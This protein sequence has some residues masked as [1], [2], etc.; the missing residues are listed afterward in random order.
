MVLNIPPQIRQKNEKRNRA[1][2]PN[3]RL[4]KHVALRS[5]D[6]PHKNPTAEDQHGVL[7]LEAESRQYPE[8][9]P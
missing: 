5:Q 1:A 8:P 3:P 4:S 2:D 7:I 6:Q 9:D